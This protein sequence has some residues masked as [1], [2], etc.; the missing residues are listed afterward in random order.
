MTTWRAPGR[1]N[2]IGDHTDYNGGLAM[3]F[4]IDLAVTVDACAVPGRTLTA[5]SHERDAVVELDL[6]ALPIVSSGWGAFVAGCVALLD[7]RGVHVKGARLTVSSTLPTGA[8]LSS[9]AALTCAMLAALLDLAGLRWTPQSI[10]EAAQIVENRHVGVPTGSLDQLAVCLSKQACILSIDFAE[11]TVESIPFRCPGALI[12][13]DTRTAH[14][15]VTGQYARRREE[16][17]EAAQALGVS[18]LRQ[19]TAADVARLEQPVL[20]RR[21][22]HVF[23]ENERVRQVREELLKGGDPIRIGALLTS[24][25]QSLRD[26]YEVSSPEL[27][28]AVDAALSAGAYGARMTGGGFGGS[29]LALVPTPAV[30]RVQAA[31]TLAA[32]RQGFQRPTVRAVRPSGPLTQLVR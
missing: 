14:R 2:L 9:S 15:H 11:L 18:S 27:N 8:G 20:K 19:A 21:A 3:P 5:T 23:S 10:A 24:S 28:T 12:V 30:G 1:V 16:S 25:H 6:D 4:A 13:V 32:S 17:I 22:Q 29:A 7:E 31:V 26:D